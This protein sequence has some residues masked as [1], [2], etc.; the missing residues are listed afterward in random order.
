MF[1]AIRTYFNKA[2]HLLCWVHVKDD[3]SQKLE[4]FIHEAPNEIF[5]KTSG[6]NKV[7]ALLDVTLEDQFEL[8]WKRL[9]EMGKGRA[10]NGALLLSYM[11]VNKRNIMKKFMIAVTRTPCG[12]ENTSGEYNQNANECMSSVL[13]R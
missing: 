2:D 13:K 5:R 10:D 6:T 12:L 4:S 9:L 11:N 8:E 3:I 1:E 7:K